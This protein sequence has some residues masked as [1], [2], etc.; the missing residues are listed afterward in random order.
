MMNFTEEIKNEIISAAESSCGN[1]LISAFIRTS[2][3]II[4]RNGRFGFEI[5]TENEKTAEFITEILEN[6]FGLQLTVSGA[7]FDLLS[8]K[9]KL[10]F[11]CA[12]EKSEALLHRLGIVGEDEDGKFLTF[13]LGGELLN[14]D[15]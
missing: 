7:K 10:A 8:G 6:K 13:D 4:S 14:G 15:K 11:E 9:D 12:D 3:S 5:V 1:A 2:G